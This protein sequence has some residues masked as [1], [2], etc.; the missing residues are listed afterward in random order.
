MSSERFAI[1]DAR[2]SPEIARRGPEIQTL[3]QIP[4]I[5]RNYA[6]AVG[7]YVFC[8]PLLR[9]VADVETAEIDS[10][11]Q[12]N[13]L[14]QSAGDCLHETPHGLT[15]NGLVGVGGGNDRDIIRQAGRESREIPSLGL[16]AERLTRH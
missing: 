7:A 15:Q 11:R 5:I 4:G 14:L 8:K 6:D 16:R 9:G 3:I 12:G 1:D 2:S 10:Y 13:A